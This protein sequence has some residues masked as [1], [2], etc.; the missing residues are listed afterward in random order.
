MKIINPCIDE[1]Y[2]K[3]RFVPALFIRYE[4]SRVKGYLY[5]ELKIRTGD[6]NS[7]QNREMYVL[8]V[9]LRHIYRLVDS[10]F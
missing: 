10:F 3:N 7:Y 1:S 4:I 9:N 8:L 2:R 5:S 6:K